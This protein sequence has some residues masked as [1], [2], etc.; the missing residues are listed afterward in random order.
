MSLITKL[1]N[2]R[3]L[4][5]AR[6]YY[7]NG[8]VYGVT[9]D[10][11]RH[12]G[13]GFWKFNNSLLYDSTYLDIIN[14]KIDDI[15][16]QY[17]VPV[18]LFDNV[19][20]FPDDEIQFVINDQLFLETLLMEIRGKSISYSSYIKKK[21]LEKENKLMEE[22]ALLENSE[23]EQTID[24]LI[25]K[26][27][28]LEDMRKEK[29]K[30]AFIRSR[31]KW[32]EEGEKPSKYFCHLESRNFTNKLIPK[33]EEDNGNIISEQHEILEATKKFY[34]NLYSSR[35]HDIEDIDL[36][37][38]LNFNDIKKLT[39]E[40]SEKLEGTISLKEASQT[41]FKMKSN[42]SPGSD[43]FTAEVFK[44][45]DDPWDLPELKDLGTPWKALSGREK[46][47]RIIWTIVRILLLVAFLYFFICSLDFLSSAFR[48]LGGRYAG[49][50]FQDNELLSNP[51]CGVMIGV[52]ATVLVQS[53]STSTS[54]V[55]SMVGSGLISVRYGIPIVMGANIG[56][57]VTN[58]IVSMG[59]IVSK[60]DFR[61]AFAGAT[62]HDMFNWITVIVLIIIE[63]PTHYLELISGEIVKSIST[64]KRDTKFNILKAVTGPFTKAIIQ[65][66]KKGITKIATKG[67]ENVKSL[68]KDCCGKWK[69]VTDVAAN[70]SEMQ[71][72]K[73]CEYLFKDTGLSEKA[74]G[75]ILLAI[76][77]VLLFFCLF[78][79]VKT[80]NSLLRGSIR[81]GIKKFVNYEFPGPF[82]YFTGYVAILIGT[83][84]TII[85]QSS[86]VFTS[87]LTPLVGVGVISIERMYPLTL[88]SNI[89]T[90]TTAILAALAQSDPK[91][92][93]NSL[94]LALCHLFFN[95]SGILLFYPLPFMRFPITFA[96]F[97]GEETAKY[98]WF[99]AAYLI[100]MFG[101][102]PALV[103]GLST[104]GVWVLVGV[105]IP[106]A[107]LIIAVIIIKVIQKKKQ[108]ILPAKL[109]NWK[110]LPEPLR[111]LA[112]MNRLCMKTCACCKCCKEEL[113]DEPD[114]TKKLEMEITVVDTQM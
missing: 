2:D 51:V 12:R 28:E 30:G 87:T 25:S 34:E 114:T 90:T 58:T 93:Q 101:V 47:F 75:G 24:D 10:E 18:Y 66:D 85:V 64:G 76:S 35:E 79:I 45:E 72:N 37:A 98:R 106:F 113:P 48:L 92:F 15:K 62:V 41:L 13:R 105:G 26:Q 55:I 56:T 78:A 17:A 49:K 70:V 86:S 5:L 63:A 81:E 11:R 71:C 73:P 9:E 1:S 60:N 111:S 20:N 109:R 88:G 110:F 74:I 108:S 46:C 14:K 89:G 103:F 97:L 8:H 29:L 96:K 42:K 54:I 39:E 65:V 40:E 94:Q 77:L 53:S 99:A 22:I 107:I 4:N 44:A 27:K 38:E 84:F 95:L 52:L 102:F 104:A 83:I 32:V 43:G 21:R 67:E 69:N 36:N 33:I 112:P 57:S 50:V 7:F 23:Q 91:D 61:R 100:V 59:Q 6:A 68:L 82:R 19:V 31:A 16:K 3:K 80:L